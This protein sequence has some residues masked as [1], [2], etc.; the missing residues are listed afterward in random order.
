MTQM[1]FMMIQFC[2]WCL[3]TDV[4]D[5]NDVYNVFMDDVWWTDVCDSNDI[6]DDFVDDVYDSNDVNDDFIDDV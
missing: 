5:S 4:Y 3:S 1:M 6:Y 2:G